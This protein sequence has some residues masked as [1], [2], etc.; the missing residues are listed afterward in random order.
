MA[1]LTQIETVG[2]GSPDNNTPATGRTLDVRLD[3]GRTLVLMVL[4]L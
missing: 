1:A 2:A 4:G 3:V